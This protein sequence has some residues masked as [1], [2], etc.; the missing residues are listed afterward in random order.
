M[1]LS[2]LPDDVLSY[3]LMFLPRSQV[4]RLG[5]ICTHFHHLIRALP[6]W[7]HMTVNMD[8]EGPLSYLWLQPSVAIAAHAPH[9]THI[10][11]GSPT[12][13]ERWTRVTAVDVCAI[14][15]LCT[16]LTHFHVFVPPGQVMLTA[17]QW[18]AFFLARRVLHR[19]TLPFKCLALQ[20]GDWLE[21]TESRHMSRYT[22]VHGLRLHGRAPLM[23]RVR[24]CLLKWL[25]PAKLHSLKVTDVANL[26]W[27]YVLHHFHALK[28]FSVI[29]CSTHRESSLTEA[30]TWSQLLTRAHKLCVFNSPRILP[31]VRHL[32]NLVATHCTS[33]PLD[34]LGGDVTDTA[35]MHFVSVTTCIH[36][37]RVRASDT[38]TKVALCGA[39]RDACL[40]ALKAL[41]ALHINYKFMALMG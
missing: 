39:C 6:I 29:R 28:R 16:N 11:F 19:V 36:C 10:T 24:P 37:T 38:T 12:S 33:L 40:P 23:Q 7:S 5:V 14:A 25:D 2:S 22:E 21:I 18:N 26:D 9:I 15:Q 17:S 13:L 20:P 32:L 34:T 4:S 8:R 3:I 1:S 30:R 27:E 41:R 31:T 35:F